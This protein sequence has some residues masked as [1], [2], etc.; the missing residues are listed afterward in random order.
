MSEEGW[1]VGLLVVFE[2]KWERESTWTWTVVECCCWDSCCSG[3]DFFLL[4]VVA[5]L[6]L[7]AAVPWQSRRRAVLAVLG[8]TVESLPRGRPS[9]TAGTYAGTPDE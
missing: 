8:A 7:A 4:V 2:Q 3:A 6:L 5:L 1:P 9:S